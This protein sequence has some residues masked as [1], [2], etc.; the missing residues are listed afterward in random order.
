MSS[1]SQAQAN[2]GQLLMAFKGP[3]RAMAHGNTVHLLD[4]TLADARR[5]NKKVCALLRLHSRS[6]QMKTCAINISACLK[7]CPPHA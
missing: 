6:D 5:G 3:H 2:R 7:L 1:S 4:A